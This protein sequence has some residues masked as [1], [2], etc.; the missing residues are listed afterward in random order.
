M[1]CEGACQ[2]CIGRIRTAQELDLAARLRID[3]RSITNYSLSLEGAPTIK[4]RRLKFPIGV[5]A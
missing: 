1:F 4:H 5:A 2:A 3:V